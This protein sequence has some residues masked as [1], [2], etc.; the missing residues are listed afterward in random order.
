MSDIAIA[1]KLN[2]LGIP[3]P[4]AYKKSIGLNFQN[5]NA[6]TNSGLWWPATVR[7]ILTDETKMGCSVQGKTSAFDHKRHKQ[8]P[9]KKEDYVIV[10]NCHEK[11]VSEELF[12]T[13]AQVRSTRSRVCKQTGE[14]HL[15]AGLVCCSNCNITMKKTGARG[16]NYLI[17]KTYQ[18]LGKEHCAQKVSINF[19]TL[20]DIV[21]KVIQ[22]QIGLVADLQAI[23]AEIDEQIGRAHV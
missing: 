23:V 5:K 10:P 7:S 20:K 9:N 16:H 2:S 14:V 21:L 13:V 11:A 8:I 12:N 1:K 18:Y 17:C 15:F 6:A 4:T 3:N 22:A 19:E